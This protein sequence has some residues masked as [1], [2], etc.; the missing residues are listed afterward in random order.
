MKTMPLAPTL[1][2]ELTLLRATP[3]QRHLGAASGLVCAHG[4]V[5][6]VGDDEHHLALFDDAHAPGRT[7]RLFDGE[8]PSAKKARKR[9]KPDTETLALL[10]PGRALLALGSGSRP[11]RCRAALIALDACGQPRVPPRLIDLGPLY[12]SLRA[13]FP[14]LNI[15]GAFFC[16]GEFVLLQ[17][18]HRG[19]APNASVH[20]RAA[21]TLAWLS[22]G[23]D[24]PAVQRVC[25]HRLPQVQGVRLTFTDASALADGRW[26]FSAVAEAT[27]DSIADGAVGLM[28]A[29]G[30]MQTLWRLP[31]NEKVEGIAVRE[32][33]NRIDI[34]LVTDADDPFIASRLLVARLS[35]P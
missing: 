4:R 25:E 33:S 11:N 19:G 18:G 10:P 24:K 1:L 27:D 32:R 9:R 3:G 26:L 22:R 5:Y 34:A 15:E 6:V 13:R 28:S 30:E 21:D 8:L 35:A 7:L 31:G 20:Y 12:E 14:D 17:R 29:R 16:A 23:A 2:R